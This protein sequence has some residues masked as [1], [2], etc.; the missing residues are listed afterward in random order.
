MTPEYGIVPGILKDSIQPNF[1]HLEKCA[2]GISKNCTSLGIQSYSQMMI[3]VPSS[4]PIR[5]SYLG[6]MKP[7]SEGDWIPRAKVFSG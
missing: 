6:S 3:G 4:P 1:H 5:M 7:F 2:I